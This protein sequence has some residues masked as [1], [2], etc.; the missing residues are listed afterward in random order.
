MKRSFETLLKLSFPMT[1]FLILMGVLHP[2]GVLGEENGIAGS[3]EMSPLYRFSSIM[4]AL[5][6]GTLMQI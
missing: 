6:K 3:K 1:V 5:I 4:Y 2:R